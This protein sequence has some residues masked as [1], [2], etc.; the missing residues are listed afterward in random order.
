MTTITTKDIATRLGLAVSTVGRAL[1]DDPR[2]SDQTK[3]RVLRAAEDMG[4]VGNRAAR[5]MRG[6]SSNTVGLVIPDIRNSFYATIAHELSQNMAAQG[7]QLMLSET[8]D[9]REAESRQLREL[10]D[11]R[12]AA[13][14]IVPTAD[15]HPDTVTL[16]TALPHVQLLRRHP[17]LG[18]AYFG[19]D[20]FTTVRSA[21]AFLTGQ[22]HT[23]IGYIGGP[24]ELSTGA[25]RL[26]GFHTALADAG[27]PAKTG[28]TVLGPPASVDHGRTALRRLL[29]RTAPPTALVTGSVL[30]TLGIMEE[31]Y[32]SGTRV[33][34]E[35]SVVGFGDEPGFA[36]WGPG[37]T[38]MRLPV[39]TMAAD[40]ARWLVTRLTEKSDDA[41]PSVTLPGELIQ[42]GSTATAVGARADV[43]K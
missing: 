5:M 24:V 42:R 18:P 12:A 41:S 14:I 7:L 8:A 1:A 25:E 36:W 2:I 17:S 6:A 23:R 34:D 43:A 39:A 37:L 32:D 27:L 10:S 16:L 9:D 20:D 29:G 33:P 31:L 26:R 40:C 13:V 15:P 4:Y 30:L 3:A 35:L 28:M 38:T 22:G 11:S 21:T 19:L